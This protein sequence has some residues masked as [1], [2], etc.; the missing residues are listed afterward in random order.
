ME[1][2]DQNS[3][4][5]LSLGAID[6][7]LLGLEYTVHEGRKLNILSLSNRK[8]YIVKDLKYK[9]SLNL[10]VIARGIHL[11]K[12]NRDNYLSR[13]EI[14]LLRKSSHIS[15][16]VKYD[17]SI[18]Y[19]ILSRSGGTKYLCLFP[20]NQWVDSIQIAVTKY[21]KADLQKGIY[22]LLDSHPTPNR[23]IEGVI[24]SSY[25][26]PCENPRILRDSA[27][28]WKDD[29][30][31]LPQEFQDFINSRQRYIH[32]VYSVEGP[33]INGNPKDLDQYFRVVYH[34][35]EYHH[36]PGSFDPVDLR[37]SELLEIEYDYGLI[38]AKSRSKHPKR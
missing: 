23:E 35:A 17:L 28:K 33:G 16:P 25:T 38:F 1:R 32:L 34:I 26:H 10:L 8:K 22:D 27:G 11:D 20:T 6:E 36:I 13:K 4:R 5:G 18:S 37:E 24:I 12:A 3:G 29:F 7:T 14:S 15:L 19:R 31:T 2:K 21:I 30:G 9:G